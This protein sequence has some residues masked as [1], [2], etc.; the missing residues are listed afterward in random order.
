VTDITS[1]NGFFSLCEIT[2]KLATVWE[3]FF[4]SF[5]NFEV[6][7]NLIELTVNI[8]LTFSETSS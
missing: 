2:L 4:S 3:R 7:S 1:N 5:N 8:F 6:V